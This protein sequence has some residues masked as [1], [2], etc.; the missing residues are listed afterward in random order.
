MSS[1]KT[2]VQ[3]LSEFAADTKIL[4]PAILKDTKE[5]ILDVLGNSLAAR[6]E[7]LYESDPDRAV[8]RVVAA[9]GG[10]PT[11]SVIGSQLM[12]P[13]ASAALVNGTLAHILDFD[14]THLPSV[15][16]PSASI[17]PTALAV[18]Q[19]VGASPDQILRSVAIGI[20]ITNRLGMAS[21]LPTEGNSIFFEKGFHATSICGTIGS[22]VTAAILYGLDAPTI[23]NAMGIASSMGAGIIEANRTGGSVKRIHCGWAAHSG[24]VAASMAREGITG[25]PTVLEGRFGF[26]NAYLGGKYDAKALLDDLGDRWELLKTAYKPYPTNHFTHPGIDCALALRA[27]GVNA[28]D[29]ESIELGVAGPVI[30]TIGEPLAEK[31]R[32]KSGYH[33]KF[34]APYTLATAFLG[35]G[36]LGVYLDDFSESNWDQAERLELA[37]KV[38]VVADDRA[39]QLF[40]KAFAAVLTVKTK[41]GK[42]HCH[43]VDASLGSKESPL[44]NAQIMQKFTL[45]ASRYL[46]TESVVQVS[47]FVNFENQDDLGSL[48]K[49]LTNNTA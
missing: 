35:G 26:F 1:E 9:W 48:M 23:A 49:L 13:A 8:E 24:V 21:Y 10:T 6:A 41:D 33:G 36:G 22:S 46:A 11:S 47:K 31:I 38:N 14:D 30:R 20:E 42:T 18:A 44:T 43:R 29:I 25:P 28:N 17:V 5:R 40:P 27:Q 34:S 3:V 4:A 45:N 19:E 12:L 2:H 39:T 37:E 16:H 7:S 15:L 32:P